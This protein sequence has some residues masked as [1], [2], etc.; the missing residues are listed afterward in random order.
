MHGS[1]T[2]NN[3]N[4]ETLMAKGNDA[5][6]ATKKQPAK[7]LTEKRKVKNAKKA[8]PPPTPL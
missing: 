7:T 3:Q 1:P 4:E 8:E 2:Q 6:K 5:K